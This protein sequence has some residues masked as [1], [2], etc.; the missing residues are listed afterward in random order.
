VAFQKGK[1]GNPSGRPKVTEEHLRIRQLAQKHTTDAFSA[2]LRI[3]RSKKSADSSVVAAATAILD[4]GW[5][6][7]TQPITGAG[8]TPLIP[9]TAPQWII[10][11]VATLPPAKAK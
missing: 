7:P 3:M 2:L 4:R 9:E 8:D 1:S 10:Q 6:K 5:G 11:P